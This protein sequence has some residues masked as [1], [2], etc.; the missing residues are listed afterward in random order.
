MLVEERYQKI[1]D[2]MKDTGSIR[3]VELQKK[4]HVSSETV[5]RDLENMEAQ[6]LI[7]RARGG[8]FLK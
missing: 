5:R 1:L 4:L 2:L 6:G 3:G 7:R 8:A